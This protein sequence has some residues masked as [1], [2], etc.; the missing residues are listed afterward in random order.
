MLAT[1]N[2]P[3]GT[4]R[5]YIHEIPRLFADAIHKALPD[6]TP[7]EIVELKKTPLSDALKLEWCGSTP[8]MLAFPVAMTIADLA[9][10][11]P[12]SLVYVESRQGQGTARERCSASDNVGSP[13]L[14]ALHSCALQ[15]NRGF[16]R[17]FACEPLQW[18]TTHC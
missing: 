8:D 9:A 4:E 12:R 1:I 2:L 11:W 10:L 5:I 3:F 18:S 17:H 6:D 15:R 16:A 14:I 13:S 7:R